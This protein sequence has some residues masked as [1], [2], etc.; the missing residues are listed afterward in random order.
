MVSKLSPVILGM[1]STLAQP[2]CLMVPEAVLTSAKSS[3]DT[4]SELDLAKKGGQK[5]THVSHAG[6][7]ATGDPVGPRE[8]TVGLMEPTLDLGGPSM[9]HS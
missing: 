9:G 3:L 1:S 4:L 6:Q 8:T 7:E 5:G 2:A